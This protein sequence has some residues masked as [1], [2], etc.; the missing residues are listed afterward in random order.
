[1]GDLSKMQEQG[2]HLALFNIAGDFGS[3]IGPLVAYTLLPVTGL[4]AVYWG[5]AI[6]M[7]LNAFWIIRFKRTSPA[8]RQ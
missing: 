7:L 8:L 1:M 3:A 2:K 4:I 6:L 5:C